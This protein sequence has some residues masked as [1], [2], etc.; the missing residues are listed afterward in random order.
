M[1]KFYDDLARWWYLISAPEDYADEARFFL[2]HF[3]TVTALSDTHLLELGSGGGNNAFHMKHAF[4]KVT[5]SDLSPGMLALSQTLNPDCE[6]I[7]GDMRHLRLER[8]FDA[9]LIHDAI[10]YMTTS[11]D[12]KQALTTAYLHC[13]PGGIAL[14]VPDHTQET[15]E[16]S[17]E[18]GGHDAD[19]RSARYLEWT[20][21]PH[22]ESNY[23][24]TDYVFILREEGHS[25]RVEHELHKLGLFRRDEWLRLMREIGFTAHTVQDDY[26]R[27][28]FVGHR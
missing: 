14:F 3:Q 23:Y 16:P 25:T 13:G 10:D 9:V 7:V 24:L 18:H 27:T 5:L 12:L 19:G 15:F 8:Q 11:D 26:G 6:H 20:Y 2:E 21:R 4:D 28:I 1:N 17:T 22:P